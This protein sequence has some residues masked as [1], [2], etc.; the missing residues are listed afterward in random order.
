MEL[1]Y[2]V[3]ASYGLTFILVYGK[4]FEDLRPPKDYS[5]KWNTLWHCPLCIGFWVGCF[6]FVRN[7]VFPVTPIGYATHGLG[8]GYAQLP[9]SPLPSTPEFGI[10]GMTTNIPTH[11]FRTLRITLMLSLTLTLVPRM[12][13]LSLGRY[14]RNWLSWKLRLLG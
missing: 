14:M 4:I 5:K 9:H 6:P 13:T 1:L 7:G 2:F 3:L 11:P 12:A 8:N 10:D